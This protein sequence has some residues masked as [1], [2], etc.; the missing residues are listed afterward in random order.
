MITKEWRVAT[1][2]DP[3]AWNQLTHETGLSPLVTSILY[4]RGYVTPDQ[5]SVFLQPELRQLR[6]PYSLRHMS[7]AVALLLPYI[8]EDRR[9]VILGDYDVDGI[10]ATAILIEFLAACGCANLDF[11]IPNRLQHGY[12]LTPASVEVLFSMQ[13]EIVITVDNGITAR[14]E[15]A[16]LQ[17]AGIPVLITDHHLASA[18]ALPEAVTINPNHPDCTY[19]FKKISG[20]G[21][22]FKLAMALRKE[23][24]E[25]GW[26][27]TARP[28]PNLKTLLD[29]AAMGTVA[30]V[31]DL[32]D[33][34]RL[35][36]SVGLEQMNAK[37]RPAVQALR[38]V[39]NVQ[40]VTARTLGFQF[41]PLMNAAGR[42]SDASLAVRMLLSPTLEEALP[43]VKQLNEI[44]DERRAQEQ[45]M[46][47]I[48][49]E[50]AL[51]QQHR[52][53]LVLASPEFHEGINGIVAARM[54][55]KYYKPTLIVSTHNPARYS[56]SGRAIEEF[57]LKEALQECEE[58]LMRFGGHAG[59]A[60]CTIHPEQFDAFRERFFDV[61]AQ[62]LPEIPRPQLWLDGALSAESL[63]AQLVEEVQRL[64]PFG[65]ANPEPLFAIDAPSQPFQILK[66]KHVKW[67]LSRSAEIIG[68]NF[69][70]AFQT[71][72]PK[73]LAVTLGFNEFRGE[74]KVQLLLKEAA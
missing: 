23:L 65:A 63:N 19:P 24:R 11:F 30:D 31:V 57:H 34:N 28:E 20:C 70:E 35:M 26:W 38:Q 42:L 51:G 3:T 64:E 56:G 27:H 25:M 66:E 43:L 17:Q 40:E 46:L 50:Q 21:V 54:V 72:S 45:D 55:E 29:F 5:A 16:T 60:G 44:N 58:L 4:H 32:R 67:A 12:G 9:I 52:R 1:P 15:V 69:A 41:A 47:R 68:W 6:D 10:T 49:Q 71:Q 14:A 73:Q 2:P 36:V 18:D 33:E 7:E 74:R 22:A 61:C 48:A 53:G 37:P 13:P 8:R 39:K 59:A 62:R